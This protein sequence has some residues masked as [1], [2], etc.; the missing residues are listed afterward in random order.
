MDFKYLQNLSYNNLVKIGED[1]GISVSK[2]KDELI[3]S[4][5]VC[6][7]EYEEYKKEKI[8]KY[9]RVK[10]IGNKGKEGVTYLVKTQGGKT[11][12]M[13]T[14]KKTKSSDRLIQEAELQERASEFGISPEVIDVDTVSKYIV[15]EKLD[16][17]LVD[18]MEEQKGDLTEDQ[19]KQIIN[20][21]KKLDQ[22]K[23]F[24]GDSNILNYMLKK[25]RI[26]IIDFGMSKYIDD[27]LMKKLGTNTPNF[28]LMNLGFIL[29]LKELECPPTA[30]C[31]LLK[32][33]SKDDK[34]KYGLDK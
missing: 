8:D 30:Y 6:F 26:Y 3:D 9:T 19:Q 21:Y 34:T 29:K 12:A 15:M 25:N 7:K 16:K 28:T 27:K 14:F 17:H 10:Q 13:K 11:F 23:V 4:I 20:I 33:V 31:Y 2:R 1:M 18:I 5:L 32:F 22:A 24:H